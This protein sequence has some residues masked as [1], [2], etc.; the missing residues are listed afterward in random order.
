MEEFNVSKQNKTAANKCRLR[1]TEADEAEMDA[2]VAHLQKADVIP[3]PRET[4]VDLTQGI[5]GIF[6][7]G[8]GRLITTE[9][10]QRI[11]RYLDARD[12]AR[13]LLFR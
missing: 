10:D 1:W 9:D 3:V 6:L 5:R 2:A 8:M 12:A 13:K 11:D 7:S 4:L